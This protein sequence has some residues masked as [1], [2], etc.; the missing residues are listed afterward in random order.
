MFAQSVW[1]HPNRGQWDQRINYSIDLELGKLL[2]ENGGFTCYLT[3]YL[4]HARHAEQDHHE[5]NQESSYKYHVLRQSFLGANQQSNKIEKGSSLFYSNYI[6]GND[7]S[8][9][10]SNIHAVSEVTF[11][12]FY[13]G[14]DMVYDS[15]DHQLRYNFV[16]S[17]GATVEDIRFQ[18]DGADKIS[19]TKKGELVIFNRFGKL[20]ESMPICWSV[21]NEGKRKNVK[22]SF[23][24]S[25]NIV[26]FVVEPYDNSET[27]FIDPS[28]T[29]STFTGSTADNWGFTAT[30][31]ANGNLFGGGIVFST[32]YPLT[33]GA[34]DV[35]FNSGSGV[36]PMDIGITKYSAN[37]NNLLYST[38][39]GGSGNETPHSIVCSPNG[40]LFIY[41]ITSSTNFPMAGTPFDNSYNGGPY[42]IEN[43]LEFNGA[44]I[45][46]ARLNANGTSLLSS[47]YVGG[48]NTDGLNTSILDYNYGDQFRGEIT[49]DENNNVYISSTTA[50]SNFPTLNAAQAGLNGFQDA[51]IFKLNQNLSTMAWSTYFGGTGDE[52]G[53]SITVGN[54]GSLYVAG[55]TT[56]FTL[57]ISAGQDLSFNGGSS[58][59]YALRLNTASGAIQSGTYM[60]SNEY[61][62]TYFVQTDL[63][64]SVYVYGQTESS[65]SISPGCYGVPNSGQFIRKYTA[66]LSTISWT[67]MIGSASGHVEIS[68]TAFLVSDCYDIY[69]AGWGGVL[70]QNGQA[71]FSTSSGF[72]ITADAY[73]P[74]TNGSNFYLAVLDQDATFLKYA[75]FMGGTTS[76]SNHVDGGTSRFDKSGRIYHA[77]CGG[78]GGSD[79][80]FTSTP[81]SWS[82]TNNSTNCNMATFKFELSTIQAAAA[83]PAPL[84]CIPQSVF[85]QNNSTNGNSYLW[86]FGDGNTSTEFAPIYQYTTPGIYEVTLTVSDT[87]GCFSSDS[88][89]I[90]LT[91]GAFEGGVV[92]PASPI[93]PG[94]SFQFEAFGGANYSWSPA[95]F[96]NNPSIY[97]PV[98]TITQTTQ[99]SVTISDSCGSVTIPVTLEVYDN[100]ISISPDTSVC[101]GNSVPL[102]V[103]SSG[104]ITWSPPTY[105]NNPSSFSPI[106]TPNQSITYTASVVNIF[107]CENQAQVTVDVFFNPP[108]P[109]MEDT[110]GMCL[111]GDIDLFISGG[112]N[113]LWQNSPYLNT[114][115]GS[116]VTAN[117]P[118]E[119]WFYVTVTNACGSA[120]D[121]VLVQVVE[122]EIF[123]GND[124]II[125]PREIA[126]LWATGA[127]YYVWNP[128]SSIVG[129]SGNEV[130]VMPT[131]S[132]S[133]QVIG[134]DDDGCK[135]TAYVLVQLYPNPAIYMSPDVLAFYG[136]EIQ[137][138]AVTNTPGSFTWYP[139]EFLSCANCPNPI[140]TPNQDITYYVN[141]EDING[142]TSTAWVNINYNAVVYVPNTFIPDNN[143]MNDVFQVYGGNIKEMECLIFN[144]W[145]ELITTLSS[146]TDFWDGT[147]KGLLCPDGTYTWKLIYKDF[148]ND[149]YQLNGHVNLLR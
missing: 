107:G 12:D 115:Q 121:S 32:G 98:A 145:G 34:Y 125:C 70:N 56:S 80:G 72:P 23:S 108:I 73:Q 48:S 120:E 86:D 89:S 118:N 40:E 62:Q 104:T 93:C 16:V 1:M 66:D 90:T 135:D 140:A 133:Y 105:L 68:P 75:T 117:P 96:L 92:P 102:Q 38:Y 83:Q 52:T 111:G 148:L 5:T 49:L 25:N 95:Q 37:G 8:H 51:V 110:V 124:T 43:S 116:V 9:W 53:N 36:F 77:V 61:D 149:K 27:L 67:T 144:R 4:Q 129:T 94:G 20:M 29:F 64:G 11:E 45:Y 109:V 33:T 6:L 79:F 99:F 22:C 58:D 15:K 74:V 100:S 7:S 143:G 123:A 85:F 42:E 101:I 46:V 119:S 39:L 114:N 139:S 69:L 28:L 55:G 3:D 82:P 44:D 112:D 128:S 78:C 142:C 13:P 17:P 41:G 65:W 87:N 47:T 10:K 141:F 122:A 113:Y 50:S 31:D 131:Q 63:S 103:N 127:S 14:I 18:I 106:S 91:I 97:N 126:T 57:P 2:I 59:G 136:D 130:E 84:I 30:P 132:T 26:S 54:S 134:T 21:N 24:L 19:L 146:T 76:S 138:E 35:S 60:G 88:V 147:Y 71:S 81:G 137:L